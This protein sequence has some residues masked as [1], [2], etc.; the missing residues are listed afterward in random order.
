MTFWGLER[1]NQNMR[2]LKSC[3]APGYVADR[4]ERGGCV[5]CSKF[6]RQGAGKDEVAKVWEGTTP[7]LIV[8]IELVLCSPGKGA[9]ETLHHRRESFRMTRF[10][11]LDP[12]SKLPKLRR[13]LLHHTS[14]LPRSLGQCHSCAVC[15]HLI[16]RDPLHIHS[17]MGVYQGWKK[18]KGQGAEDGGCCGS[19]VKHQAGS[20]LKARNLMLLPVSWQHL[21]T[22]L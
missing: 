11:D 2:G 3:V 16:H 10:Q 5:L 6:R 17:A 21:L 20:W 8:R 14:S 9:C 4:V 7:S 13:R 12:W 1:R 18:K 19:N 22:M 15:G